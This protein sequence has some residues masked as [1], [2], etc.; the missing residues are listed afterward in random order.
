M[1]T[2][3][4]FNGLTLTGN[5]NMVN[6]PDGYETILDIQSRVL[7]T[8]GRVGGIMITD[9]S[10]SVPF[11]GIYTILGG[12]DP[13]FP[14]RVVYDAI[15]NKRS[16]IGVLI[17]NDGDPDEVSIPNI[18]LKLVSKPSELGLGALRC[19]LSFELLVV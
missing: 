1:T 8:P 4:K 10:M 2:T 19:I 7:N 17:F 16:T 9:A 12:T 11:T 5:K 18:A 13:T 14:Q 3:I 6:F 15:R